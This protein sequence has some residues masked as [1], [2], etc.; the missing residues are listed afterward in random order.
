MLGELAIELALKL[1][2]DGARQGAETDAQPF[3]LLAREEDRDL[4][5]LII[6]GTRRRRGTH[7]V[8]L[9]VAADG[10]CLH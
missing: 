8:P 3:D 6:V 9:A 4:G 10:S 2:A 5:G 1:L 7:S